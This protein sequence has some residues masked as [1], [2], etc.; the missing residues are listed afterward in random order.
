[1]IISANSH[2]SDGTA[3]SVVIAAWPNSEGLAECLDSLTPQQDAATEILVVGGASFPTEIRA[4]FPS[5]RWLQGSPDM[6]V[7]H[8]WSI[9]MNNSRGRIVAITTARFV[10]AR[11]WLKCI[12]EAH[13]R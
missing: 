2:D 7:P 10:P 1:M 11:D 3:S 5:V 6:L 9:G 13:E 4:R 8:L 12:R